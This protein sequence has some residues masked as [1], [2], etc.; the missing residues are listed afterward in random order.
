MQ[1]PEMKFSVKILL[2]L[3]NLLR[4]CKSATYGQK[5]L[6]TLNRF[7]KMAYLLRN[8]KRILLRVLRVK[9][10]NI[11]VLCSFNSSTFFLS[12]FQNSYLVK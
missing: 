8:V 5:I 6:N 4:G 2:N 12:Q 11:S 1:F 9:Y 10:L 7:N 3:L